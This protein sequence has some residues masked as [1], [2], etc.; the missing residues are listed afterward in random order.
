MNERCGAV[1]RKRC[2]IL[3]LVVINLA[4]FYSIAV[5]V[6]GM[7]TP[8]SSREKPNLSPLSPDEVSR[9]ADLLMRQM[10]SQMLFDDA[11]EVGDAA[12][13]FKLAALGGAGQVALSGLRHK[14][15]VVLVFASYT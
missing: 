15:P 14:K 12:P 3:S 8:G 7:V 10:A 4:V 5:Q 2:L 11:L 1:R 13:D 6:R 9:Q